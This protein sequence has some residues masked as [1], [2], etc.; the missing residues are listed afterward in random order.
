MQAVHPTP[1]RV[2]LAEEHGA[3]SAEPLDTPLS[4]PPLYRDESLEALVDEAAKHGLCVVPFEVADGSDSLE[5]SATDDGGRAAVRLLE[6]RAWP[7]A[8]FAE[9]ASYLMEVS[10]MG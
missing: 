8:A 4:A 1:P 3:P 9:S 6:S 7:M 2:I 5:G 10:L